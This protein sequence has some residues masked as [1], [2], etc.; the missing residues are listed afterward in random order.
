M[1][2]QA[3]ALMAGTS[4]V[5]GRTIICYRVSIGGRLG[6]GGCGDPRVR[7]P[8]RVRATIGYGINF[9][10]VRNC[11]LPGSVGFAYGTVTGKASDVAMKLSTGKTVH[12]T[13]I[14]PRAGLPKGTSFF[15]TSFPCSAQVD[16]VV[17]RSASGR[18]VGKFVV[19][20]V[21]PPGVPSTKGSASKS[22]QASPEVI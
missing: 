4:R 15:F 12:V 5:N 9:G 10:D 16:A 14:R 2:G 1:H 7:P 13:P 22:D 20:F 17:A 18:I 19:P 11:G 8:A 21:G 6:G 3:W